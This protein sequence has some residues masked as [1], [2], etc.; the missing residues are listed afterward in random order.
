MDLFDP[1]QM[2]LAL[3][4][5]FPARQFLTNL[6]FSASVEH[7]TRTFQMD[8]VKGSRRLAPFVGRKKE[9]KVIDREN[10]KTAQ[11]EPPYIKEKMVT[12][13]EQI[14]T[15]R[16]GEII[17]TAPGANSPAAR[18]AMQLGEDAAEMQDMINRRI[19]WMAAQGLFTGKVPVKGDGVDA[20]VDFLFSASHLFT[21]DGTTGNEKWSVASTD[22]RTQLKAWRRDLISKDSGKTA[23]V[24]ILGQ[25]VEPNFINNEV[26]QNLLNNRRMEIGKIVPE[27]MG[28]GVTFVGD[29]TSLGLSVWTYDEWY[30]D[31]VEDVAK[32]MVPENMIL[33][34]STGARCRRHYGVIE[35]VQAGN[36]ATETF[37]KSWTVEDPSARMLMAQ[38]APLP[39]IEQPDAFVAVVVQDAAA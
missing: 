7:D 29:I 24:L 9:G 3:R 31:E 20:E 27:E 22:I 34:G 1:I 21:L 11:F 32:P 19:E 5:A 38:S 33:L 15:R 39:A 8:I 36:F 4:E 26:M 2:T 12:T 10:W 16:P 13:A 35:D 28:D 14:L 25:N 6:F 37:V 18:A 30:H 23:N 17:Y